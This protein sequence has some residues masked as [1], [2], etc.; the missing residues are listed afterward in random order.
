MVADR[1][2]MRRT[3]QPASMNGLNSYR[4]HRLKGTMMSVTRT[5]AP[6]F[7]FGVVVLVRVHFDD[8]D[9]MSMLHNSRY[10]ML[11]ERAWSEFWYGQGFGGD[12]GLEGDAFNVVKAFSITYE[13]PIMKPG[14]YSVHLWMERIG[15]TSATF[16]YRVY[17]VDGDVVH[18]LGSRTVIRLDSATLLPTPWSDQARKVAGSLEVTQ[19]EKTP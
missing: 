11:V 3:P 4:I 19:S 12:S 6:S 8:L 15:N 2:G 1:F 16:G 13:V 10:Q 14:E 17:S 7:D 5:V 18:A 9:P